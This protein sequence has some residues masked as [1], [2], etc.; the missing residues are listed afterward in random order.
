L[1]GF[2]NPWIRDFGAFARRLAVYVGERKVVPLEFAIGSMTS[3]PASVFGITDRGVI[4]P[5]CSPTSSSSIPLPSVIG[6]RTRSR[7]SWRPASRTCSSTA[8]PCWRGCEAGRT[9][10]CVRLDGAEYNATATGH[11]SAALAVTD[12]RLRLATSPVEEA[13]A[14]EK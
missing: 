14:T 13:A 9:T 12:E 6:R 2:G 8:S 7:S 10:E 1:E 4:R 11:G 3:L 5:W